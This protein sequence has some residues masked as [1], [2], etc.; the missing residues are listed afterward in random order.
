MGTPSH[1]GVVPRVLDE[2]FNRLSTARERSDIQFTV[3]CSMLE[4]ST[5]VC[6][7]YFF[8]LQISY[9]MHAVCCIL[10]TVVCVCVS[11]FARQLYLD[12]LRDLLASEPSRAA[13]LEI[14]QREVYR[15][16]YHGNQ[17]TYG[18]R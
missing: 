1:H 5:L 6:V 10:L 14:R 9:S 18:L 15:Q 8:C 2:L 3:R 16:H 12:A 4:V 11:V 13:R 17:I 7:L